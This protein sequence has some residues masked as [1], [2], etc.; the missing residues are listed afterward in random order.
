MEEYYSARQNVYFANLSGEQISDYYDDVFSSFYGTTAAAAA[1]TPY[2]AI[3]AIEDKDAWMTS[4]TP[5]QFVLIARVMAVNYG[6]T[7]RDMT[8]RNYAF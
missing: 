3:R 6:I 1:W 2:Y 4:V 8:L 7:T 5:L